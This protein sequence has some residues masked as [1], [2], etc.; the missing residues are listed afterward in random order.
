LNQAT[1]WP[2]EDNYKQMR[3]KTNTL[4]IP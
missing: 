1:S 2:T 3:H 4:G